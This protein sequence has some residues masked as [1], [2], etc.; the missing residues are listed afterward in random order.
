MKREE[1][2]ALSRRRILD[3]ATAEFS[4]S[5]YDAASMNA[6]CADNTISKGIIYHYYKDKDELYLSCVAACFDAITA[7]LRQA[8]DS[9][10]GTA[11]QRLQAYFHARL[12]FFAENPA[13]LGIFASAVFAPPE[14]LAPDVAA[15][16]RAFDELNL[17]VM[18]A[19]I[20]SESLRAGLSLDAVI[21]DF[22]MYMDYFNLRF[23]AKLSGGEP[24]E[25]VLHEHE[26]R[27]QRQL[28]ILLYGV[29]GKK[30]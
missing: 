1:K 14:K 18:R 8:A 23:Q 28:N 30:E 29:I 13:Y 7:A 19:I 24:A 2:S 9:L 11:E 12:R 10:T 5:G 27:C 22:G 20:Q 21:Q 15:L 16:R 25:A 6:L 26:E 3:A 4:R 17:S